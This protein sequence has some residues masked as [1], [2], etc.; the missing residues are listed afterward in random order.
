MQDLTTNKDLQKNIATQVKETELAKLYGI[1]GLDSVD[2]W[3]LATGWWVLITLA[4]LSLIYIIIAYFRKRAWRLSWK[5]QTHAQIT[6]WK[7]ILGE[8]NSQE[9]AIK[10]S[11]L[12]R[13]IVMHQDTRKGCA[14]LVA[15][16]WLSYLGNRNNSKFNWH[17]NGKVFTKEIFAPSGNVLSIDKLKLLL[18]EMQRWVK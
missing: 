10:A 5:G 8:D 9:I 18:N 11:E 13:R 14:S 3:P 7:Q 15:G 6:E 4:T 1:D 2:W 12:A 16:N 17:E